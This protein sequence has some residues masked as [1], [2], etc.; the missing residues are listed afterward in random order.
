MRLE[1]II[2]LHELLSR[3][4]EDYRITLTFEY[5]YMGFDFT[6][7]LEKNVLYYYIGDDDDGEST[8][9]FGLY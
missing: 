9:L 5:N 8:A 4:T 7:I 6:V 1:L 2:Q 3:L